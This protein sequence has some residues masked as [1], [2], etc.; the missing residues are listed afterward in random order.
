MKKV[1][2]TLVLTAVLIL[3]YKINVY[4]AIEEN[5][6]DLINNNDILIVGAV[7]SHG[8]KKVFYYTTAQAYEYEDLQ[9]GMYED[10]GII[11]CNFVGYK[12]NNL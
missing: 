12:N 8:V 3:T 6:N 7:D 10:G 5:I 9:V 2:I 4:A 1:I 11:Y